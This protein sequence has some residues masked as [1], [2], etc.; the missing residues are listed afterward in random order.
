MR[1]QGKILSAKKIYAQKLD[2]IIKSLEI[3]VFTKIFATCLA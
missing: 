3:L 1:I 2:K